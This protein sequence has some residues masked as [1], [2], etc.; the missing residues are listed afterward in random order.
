[1]NGIK[2]TLI[3]VISAI[4]I[5][6]LVTIFNQDRAIAPENDS[7]LVA[8]SNTITPTQIILEPTTKTNTITPTSIPTPTT[9]VETA[10]NQTYSSYISYRVPRHIE[11]ID[12]ELTLDGTTITDYNVNYSMAEG[13]S[14]QYQNSFAYAISSQIIGKDINNI[15]LYRVGG[16]SLTTGAFMQAVADIKNQVG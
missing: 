8:P 10:T 3:L 7:A 13:E 9:V 15:S 16:A 2:L 6:G 14:R 12:V 11:S 4:G 5:A 1:M